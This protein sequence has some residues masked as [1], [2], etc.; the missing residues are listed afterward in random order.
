MHKELLKSQNMQLKLSQNWKIPQF[1]ILKK[2][3]S[4]VILVQK[5]DV[6][7]NKNSNWDNPN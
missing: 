6:L 4:T 7:I 2:C 3:F 5:A 1:W